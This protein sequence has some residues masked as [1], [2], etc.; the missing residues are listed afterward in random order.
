MIVIARCFADLHR[1]LVHLFGTSHLAQSS[2]TSLQSRVTQKVLYC[3]Q[4]LHCI[5][6][7]E[8]FTYIPLLVDPARHS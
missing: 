2:S 5:T 8:T 1:F 3:V 7:P 6:V 4:P